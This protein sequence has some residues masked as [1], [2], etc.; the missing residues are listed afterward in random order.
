MIHEVEF[1]RRTDADGRRLAEP[2][3]TLLQWKSGRT[4]EVPTLTMAKRGG[5]VY[6]PEDMQ[7]KKDKHFGRG[8]KGRITAHRHLRETV[9]EAYEEEGWEFPTKIAPEISQSDGNV[10]SGYYSNFHSS[11]AWMTRYG[12]TS[13]GIKLSGYQ[14]DELSVWT[15]VP[16]ALLIHLY[17]DTSMPVQRSSVKIEW[18]PA[19]GTEDVSKFI[20]TWIEDPYEAITFFPNINGQWQLPFRD[21]DT[22]PIA[23][24]KLARI[25]QEL[26]PTEPFA[27]NWQQA[28]DA[29]RGIEDGNGWMHD[30]TTDFMLK[31]ARYR[32]EVINKS[33]QK[34][35]EALGAVLR[36]AGVKMEMDTG[37]DGT[38]R[39]LAFVIKGDGHSKHNRDGHTIV[40]RPNGIEVECGYVTNESNY[41]H[42][43]SRQALGEIAKLLNEEEK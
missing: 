42:D 31:S 30:I 35:V 7:T 37:Y 1:G 43:Q 26:E 5:W 16:T 27:P 3:A 41:V 22:P 39:S 4:L 13:T 23:N 20:E 9:R 36:E 15:M 24:A 6:K 8:E 29:Y 40:I 12:W 32:T 17:D 38:F 34:S 21:H 28:A 11:Y 19:I 2:F 25:F 14:V 10:T 18:R 33:A